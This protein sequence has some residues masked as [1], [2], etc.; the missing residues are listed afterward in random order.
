MGPP[1]SG[2]QAL[3]FGEMNPAPTDRKRRIGGCGT[4]CILGII[5]FLV[6]GLW[7][8]HEFRETYS[9]H[10][11]NS[12]KRSEV[13]L[14]L[15]ES[16]SDIS[17]WRDGL[18]YWAEFTIPEEDFR[19]LF[20]RFNFSE[21]E[22]PITVHAKQYGNPDIFPPHGERRTIEVVSGL[23]YEERWGNGGG[24]DIVYDRSTSRAFY[25]FAKR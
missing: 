5:V 22:K 1:G 13:F 15:P 25:D 2:C 8:Y 11:S 12:A 6:L 16:V 10:T 17:Y 23:Q 4:W 14:P 9:V 21:I 19:L 24:Y 7:A 20:K 3:S 18:N